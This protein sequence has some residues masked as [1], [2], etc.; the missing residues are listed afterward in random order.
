M[1]GAF[2]MPMKK[3][4]MEAHNSAY[5]QQMAAAETAERQGLYRVALRAAMDAWEHIDG[6]MQYQNK[7]EERE[8]S[9]VWA[10]DFVIKYAPLLLDQKSLNKL[11]ELLDSQRRIERRTANSVPEKLAAARARILDNHR[12]WTHLERNPDFA[13]DELRAALGGNQGQW[14][15]VAESWEKMGLV[16]RVPRHHSYLLALATRMGEVVPAK[17]PSCGKVEEAPKA[18]FLEP[19]KCPKCRKSALF[20]F[21]MAGSQVMQPE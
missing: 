18:M 12:L 7:Y 19:L 21:L 10:I 16:R 17:C 8:F 2:H 14:R 3:A 5:E 11:E 15:A 4:E 20:V 6:M 13:Q 1:I 9:D